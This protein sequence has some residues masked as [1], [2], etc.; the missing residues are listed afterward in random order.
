MWQSARML[1]VPLLAFSDTAL[2]ANRA[3]VYVSPMSWL[4]NGTVVDPFAA[5]PAHGA[6]QQTGARVVTSSS[7]TSSSSK[8]QKQPVSALAAA[9]AASMARF[10]SRKAIQDFAV[11]PLPKTYSKLQVAKLSVNFSEAV[12]HVQVPMPLPE[13]LPAGRHHVEK[14]WCSC[15]DACSVLACWVVFVC[16]FYSLKIPGAAA[17]E[18]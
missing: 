3:A 10:S 12:Q 13:Q 15:A 18:V 4:Q 7:L 14:E 8:Q 2:D 9:S 17:H 16:A 5:N 6:L 1:L 11:Q